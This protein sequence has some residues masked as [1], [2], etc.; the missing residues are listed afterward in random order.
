MLSCRYLKKEK[1]NKIENNI[2]MFEH[3][4][5][6]VINL[7]EEE[8]KEVD[9][10]ILDVKCQGN[11]DEV[12]KVQRCPQ[13]EVVFQKNTSLQKHVKEKHGSSCSCPFCQVGF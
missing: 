5:D 10:C 13:L 11:C 2:I 8:Q 9:E 4:G 7:D 12:K 1:K 6:I 3:G